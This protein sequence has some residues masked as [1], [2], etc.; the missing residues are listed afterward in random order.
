[1]AVSYGAF[2]EG[3]HNVAAVTSAGLVGLQG[4][5][6]FAGL[7]AVELGRRAGVASVVADL[8]RSIRVHDEAGVTSAGSIGLELGVGLAGETSGVDSVAAGGAEVEARLAHSGSVH[9]VSVVAGASGLRLCDEA[10]VWSAAGTSVNET[11]GAGQAV[12]V[13]AGYGAEAV[14][15]HS[16]TS[17]ASAGAVG[18]EL[19]IRLA[20]CTA[21]D[22]V[23][24]AGQASVVATLNDTESAAGVK[25]EAG[26][27]DALSI[28]EH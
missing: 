7:T 25:G 10:S 21:G 19:G 18:L 4:G 28:G 9:E 11:V 26:L 15:V 22:G 27:A 5:E 8:A 12:L 16:E 3:V 13:A 23:G 1:M 17:V 20:A 6:G 14:D 2:A 24:R